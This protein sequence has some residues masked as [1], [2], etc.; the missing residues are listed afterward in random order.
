MADFWWGFQGTVNEQQWAKLMAGLGQKYVLVNGDPVRSTGRTLYI[1][2]RLQ[3]GAGVAFEHDAVKSLAVPAPAA[4]QWHLLVARRV[5]GATPSVTYALVP[6]ITTAD[7]EQLAPPAT[8]PAGRNKTPGLTDDEPVAW[9][10]ARASTTT[11]KLWQ[12]STKRDGRVPGLWAMF[13]PNEQGI[14]S[15]FSEAENTEYVW[16]SGAWERQ[17]GCTIATLVSAALP[18]NAWF[19]ITS[20]NAWSVDTD[21]MP[22]WNNGIP[23]PAAGRYLVTGSLRVDAALQVIFGAKLNNVAANTTGM[24]AANVATGAS[25]VALSSFS[26]IIKL[27]ANDVITPVAH[28]TGTSGPY[29]ITASGTNFSVARI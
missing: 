6:G 17:S 3:I 21:S 9:V 2:P 10:H 23:V 24:F 19:P 28:T 14:F 12:M 8:L 27:A 15:I 7:A 4:G 16:K 22:A 1:D 20:A 11:L 25:G 13:D 5:W 18:S 26:A 29:G